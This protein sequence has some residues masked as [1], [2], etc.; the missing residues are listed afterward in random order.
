V[1]NPD[2]LA[3][4]I[5]LYDDV[6]KR[7]ITAEQIPGTLF[8]GKKPVFSAEVLSTFLAACWSA[9]INAVAKENA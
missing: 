2:H 6:N 1:I 7:R 3:Q 9:E 4:L 8:V 5:A